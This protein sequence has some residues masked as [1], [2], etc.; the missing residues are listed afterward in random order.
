MTGRRRRSS[1]N[2]SLY[3]ALSP[4]SVTLKK[5]PRALT[6]RRENTNNNTN[7]WNNHTHNNNYRRWYHPS[8]FISNN[9]AASYIA[10]SLEQSGLVVIDNFLAKS[11]ASAVARTTKQLHAQRPNYFAKSDTRY[12]TDYSYWVYDSS[13]YECYAQLDKIFMDLA[14]GLNKTYY[15]H[16]KHHHQQ[17]KLRSRHLNVSGKSKLQVSCFRK[18]SQGYLP[19]S[20]NPNDNGR[21]ISLVYFPNEEYATSDGAV[22]R[23]YLR[24]CGTCVNVEPRNN[25]LV[26]HWSNNSIVTETLPTNSNNVFAISTWFFGQNMKKV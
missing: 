22:K 1:T 24:E 14:K 9:I 23:F 5:R 16:Q 2:D 25:R 20:D 19:H 6:K 21:L 10:E 12:R 4:N 11:L 15:H 3:C 17:Q 26:L 7:H 8:P 18:S 13:K